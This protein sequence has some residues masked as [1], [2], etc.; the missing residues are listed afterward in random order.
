MRQVLHP[1]R[2]YPAMVLMLMP[3]FMFIVVVMRRAAVVAAVHMVCITCACDAGVWVP[4][5]D[6]GQ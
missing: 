6:L 3:V 2:V 5:G 1:G 4:K